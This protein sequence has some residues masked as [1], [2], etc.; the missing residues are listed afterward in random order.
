[1]LPCL[2]L[3]C[4]TKFVLR[5]TNQAA[6]TETGAAN[7]FA[8][9]GFDTAATRFTNADGGYGADGESGVVNGGDTRACR[10]C[11]ATDHLARECPTKPASNC[12]KCGEAG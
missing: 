12:F 6:F 5:D 10:V 4:T 3:K 1:M 7:G 2:Y 11:Q 9:G 8:D